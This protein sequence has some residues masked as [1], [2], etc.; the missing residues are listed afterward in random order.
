MQK[1]LKMPKPPRTRKRQASALGKKDYE[2]ESSEYVSKT[3][4]MAEI[5]L[6]PNGKDAIPGISDPE[7]DIQAKMRWL[8][9]ADEGLDNRDARKKA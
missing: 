1:I 2:T 7:T 9:L 8:K 6:F 4:P 5:I 3:T